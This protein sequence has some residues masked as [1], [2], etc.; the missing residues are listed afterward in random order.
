MTS[1][2]VGQELTSGEGIKH[3]VFDVPVDDFCLY[4]ID[5]TSN[6]HRRY[7]DKVFDLKIEQI[8]DAYVIRSRPSSPVASIVQ[9]DLQLFV[10]G[11][12]LLR[13]MSFDTLTYP[14]E[15]LID[16]CTEIFFEVA[17][18]FGGSIY[19]IYTD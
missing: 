18:A 4:N 3:A 5:L 9:R 7:A 2:F 8:P 17:S 10:R 12:T 16:L 6:L 11:K 13:T 1:S 15:T 14:P 19:W